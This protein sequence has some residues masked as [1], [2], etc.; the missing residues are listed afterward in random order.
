[1]CF[2]TL[3]QVQNEALILFCNGWLH[4]E[5]SVEVISLDAAW[6][7]CRQEALSHN[8]RGFFFVFF[9]SDY[10]IRESS[11]GVDAAQ[12]VIKPP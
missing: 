12:M 7:C 4:A 6:L 9:P 3:P 11:S 10:L 5:E 8:A 1:M 2:G